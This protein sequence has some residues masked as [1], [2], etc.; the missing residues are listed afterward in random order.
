MG[1]ALQ[2]NGFSVQRKAVLE[3]SGE[4]AARVP[5][6]LYS[7]H[8]AVV[9]GY[10]IEGH[11]PADLIMRLLKQRPAIDGLAVPAMP[12]GAPGMDGSGRF[13]VMSFD[14]QDR[15]QIHA[16]RPVTFTRARTK[17]DWRVHALS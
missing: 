15:V 7:C 2:A 8:T 6:S 1:G 11:V 5:P 3:S 17:H 9:E 16:R 4:R 10:V 13:D 12:V 14:R